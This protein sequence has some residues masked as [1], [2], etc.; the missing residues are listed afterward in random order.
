MGEHKCVLVVDD[1]AD[2]RESIA[3]ALSGRGWDV[4]EAGNGAEALEVLH[5]TTTPPD[6]ILLDIMMPVMDGWEFRT[7]QLHDPGLHDIPVVVFS[8]HELIRAAALD[9]GVTAFV[10][11]PVRLDTLEAALDRACS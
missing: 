9:L 8:A 1:E 4:L 11:K 10:R 3:D 5:E 2:V 6:V 7:V